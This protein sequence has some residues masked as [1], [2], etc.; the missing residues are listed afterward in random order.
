VPLFAMPPAKQ[1]YVG[2]DVHR[3]AAWWGEPFDFPRKF[4]QRT[5]AAQRLCLLAADEGVETGIRLAT[6]L[7]RAMWAEQRDLEDESMLRGILSAA[8]LPE[9]W[10]ARTQDPEIKARLAYNTSTARD[11]GVFGVPTYVVDGKH[12]FWGQDRL[13]LVARALAGWTPP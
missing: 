4:P 1:R 3:W 5:I 2:L 10:V 7:A 8:D 11:A 13:D 12:L 9:D 6:A